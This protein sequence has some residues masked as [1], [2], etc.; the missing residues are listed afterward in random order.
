LRYARPKYDADADADSD[1][2]SAASAILSDSAAVGS[3]RACFAAVVR[4]RA[5]GSQCRFASTLRK[6]KNQ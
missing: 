3:S 5:G 4:N 2:N 1:S 6:G